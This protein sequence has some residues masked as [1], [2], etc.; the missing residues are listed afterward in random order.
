MQKIIAFGVSIFASRVSRKN[1]S[2]CENLILKPVK[3]PVFLFKVMF[4]GHSKIPRL[5]L[6]ILFKIELLSTWTQTFAISE[7]FNN[8]THEILNKIIFQT[9]NSRVSIVDLLFFLLISATY[10]ENYLAR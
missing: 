7:K 10:I 3:N 5:F 6:T 1:S 9:F 8:P 2:N 4:E